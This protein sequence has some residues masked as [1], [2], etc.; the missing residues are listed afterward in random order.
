MAII[1]RMRKIIWL[2]LLLLAAVS[3]SADPGRLFASAHLTVTSP[4]LYR[5]DAGRTGQTA[6]TGPTFLET[7]RWQR[8]LQGPVQGL[9]YEAGVLYAGAFG[10]VYAIDPATGA[11]LWAFTQAGVKFSAVAIAGDAVYVSGGDTLYALNRTTG[12]LLWSVDLEENIQSSSPLIVDGVAYV[13]ST[14]GTVYAIDLA[15]HAEVW[16]HDVGSPIRY[17]LAASKNLLIVVADDAIHALKLKDGDEKWSRAGQFGPAAVSDK[18]VY[19][20]LQGGGFYALDVNNGKVEW[21]YNDPDN[22]TGRWSA[23]VISKGI[24]SAG[25][26]NGYLY[27]IDAN[28]GARELTLVALGIPPS[29]ATAGAN[30]FIY[31]GAGSDPNATLSPTE[32][33]VYD[34]TQQIEYS[35]RVVYGHVTGGVAIGGGALFVFDSSNTLTAFSD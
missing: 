7:Q 28:T 18:L 4:T 3:L 14:A 11:D 26:E 31:F 22:A 1:R 15:T 16:S 10:G 8:T 27:F 5:A 9:V 13:G 17:S 19:S 34:I 20:G 24:L 33:H 30:G 25:N 2:S 6:E 12:A 21:V 29:E 35:S 32:V 23:P